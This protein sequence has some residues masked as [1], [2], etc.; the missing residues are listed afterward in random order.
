MKKYGFWAMLL[1]ALLLLA[2]CSE[3]PEGTEPTEFRVACFECKEK[4]VAGQLNTDFGLCQ[5]CM[6]KVGAAYCQSCSA[7][8][9]IRD[10]THG[11]CG[12][13]NAAAEATTEPER[14]QCEYC[15]QS[16]LA[17]YFVEDCCIGC[18]CIRQGKCLR[19]KQDRENSNGGHCNFCADMRFFCASCSKPTI[20]KEMFLDL[21]MDCYGKA[22][23][24]LV[25]CPLCGRDLAPEDIR[26]GYCQDC[27]HQAD[28]HEDERNFAKCDYCGITY[29]YSDPLVGG[30]CQSC[31]NG[32][33]G[34]CE[35][36][37]RPY[38]D[39]D[40]FESL[41]YSC[42]D[43]YGPK[44]SV[45]GAD[46][47]YRGG[48]DGMCDDCYDAANS[49]KTCGTNL[50]YQN[51]DGYCYYCHPSF[52]ATCVICGGQQPVHLP[53]DGIC[54]NCKCHKCGAILATP[55]GINGLCDDCYDAANS[56]KTCGTDLTYQ[57]YDGYCYY[58]HP[59]FGFYCCKNCGAYFP[60][61]EGGLCPDC[62]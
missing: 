62:E 44:C 17:D 22:N 25:C 20:G 14:K 4:F 1:I 52:G 40:G 28:Y 19:C 57:N 29:G 45:C 60:A 33:A 12:S 26:G 59:D 43:K 13:C 53:A 31:W 47:T 21:C 35:T 41:C 36:C 23:S 56:C 5:G 18:Y 16:I 42:Q 38:R 49:C 46:L 30:A 10:M 39:G 54:D 2:G 6:V 55:G 15:G 61:H 3:K 58:C 51:Y 32:F 11:L 7:P 27:R 24:T 9:Y 37:G 50:T 34:L 8:C 48:I